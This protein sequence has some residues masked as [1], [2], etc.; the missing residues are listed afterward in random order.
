MFLRPTRDIGELRRRYSVIRFCH[1]LLADDFNDL[2]KSQMC[3]DVVITVDEVEFK[4]HK[5]ILVARSPVFAA[6]FQHNSKKQQSSR[7]DVPDMEHD[8]FR[9]MLQYI[10]TGKADNLDG[11]AAPLLAASDRYGLTHLKTSCEHFMIK[12]I[13]VENAFEQLILADLHLA[14]Q[15]KETV[16]KFINR[17]TSAVVKTDGWKTLVASH[18]HLVREIYEKL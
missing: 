11:M 16:I 1:P 18:P 10:Y 5:A 14:S 4:V 7:V 9:E 12:Q 2:L 13:S 15:L 6:M 3:N 17:N 8:V